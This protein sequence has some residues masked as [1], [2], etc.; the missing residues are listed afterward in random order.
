MV[1]LTYCCCSAV[2]GHFTSGGVSQCKNVSFSWFSAPVWFLCFSWKSCVCVHSL[3]PCKNTPKYCIVTN[4]SR[5]CEFFIDVNDIAYR[6][7]IL[8][9]FFHMENVHIS[10]FLFKYTHA[11]IQIHVWVPTYVYTYREYLSQWLLAST[12]KLWKVKGD[13]ALT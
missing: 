6:S 3:S 9:L 11:Y 4:R 10:Y 12:V 5:P 2:L 1:I 13:K 7:E 8:D